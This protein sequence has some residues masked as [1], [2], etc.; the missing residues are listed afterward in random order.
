MKCL[1]E[2]EEIVSVPFEYLVE[3]H[4]QINASYEKLK[5]LIGEPATRA[6]LALASDQVV[7]GRETSPESSVGKLREIF[8]GVG[9]DL[10]EKRDGD[11][12]KF[13]LA[14]PF[15]ERIHPRLGGSMTYCPMSLTVLSTIRKKYP[16]SVIVDNSL[17]KKGSSFSIR[18]EE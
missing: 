10:K 1:M 6:L 8:D 14:C 13:D 12:V 5:E 15:A 2:D 3:L 18:I 17:A 11:I 7:P 9:Y 4:S 16:K